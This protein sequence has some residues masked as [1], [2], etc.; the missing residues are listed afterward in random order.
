[1]QRLFSSFPSGFPGMG[2]ALLRA[3]LGF[4]LIEDGWQFT[5]GLAL[6]AGG[7]TRAVAALGLLWLACGALA[8]IG[9]VTPAVQVVVVASKA[10]ALG[11]LW[12]PWLLANVV[13][14]ASSQ[15]VDAILAL[16]LILLGPGAYSLDASWFGRREIKIPPSRR[17]SAD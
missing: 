17:R 2:L 16:S 8:I 13:V 15:T 3:T 11:H 14:Q 9:A 5:N 4:H 7:G 1:M 12:W 6:T 10:F